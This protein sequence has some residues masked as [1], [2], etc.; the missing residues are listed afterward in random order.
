MGGMISYS[1]KGDFGQT[2]RA[3]LKMAQGDMFSVLDTAGQRGVAAL[4]AA[5]PHDSGATAAAWSFKVKRSGR[6][7]EIEWTNSNS[8]GGAP[9]AILL[10]YGHGTGTGGYVQ[11]RDFINPAMRPVFDQIANDVWKAVKAA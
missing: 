1:T 8:A 6:S 10:Q 5:T 4:R 9:V 7:V 3:L 2:R 11:G